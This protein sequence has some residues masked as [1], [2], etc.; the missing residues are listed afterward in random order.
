MD[1]DKPV[2]SRQWSTRTLQE[3]LECVSKN[4]PGELLAKSGLS[5]SSMT[6]RA[7][8]LEKLQASTLQ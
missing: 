7:D 8:D 4:D 6:T 1:K 2:A 5:S 3:G